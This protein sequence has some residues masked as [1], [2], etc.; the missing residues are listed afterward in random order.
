MPTTRVAWLNP[1]GSGG[2]LDESRR[3]LHLPGGL[4]GDVVSWT[5]VEGHAQVDAVV[6]PSPDRVTPACPVDGQCGGCDL[7]A[8]APGA[9]RAA[10]AHMIGRAWNL[11]AAPEVEAPTVERGR[12]A[13]VELAIA[14][15]VVGYRAAR[16]HRLVDVDACGI[17]RPE[18]ND[19][20]G[21][22]RTVIAARPG[23]PTD[24]V[25]LRTDGEKAVAAFQSTRRW[26]PEDVE[27]T[28]VLD[29]VAVDHKRV[30]GDP[31]LR[32]PVLGLRLRAGPEAFFQVDLD[33]N[34][35]LVAFVRDAITAVRAERV[36]DLYAGIGNLGLPIAAGGVPVLAVE[37]DGS[38]LHDLRATAADHGLTAVKVLAMDARKFDPSRE[39]FDA[40][41][42]D[43]PRAG[44]GD[45]LIRVL[46]NRPRR[47]VLVSCD[48]L[49]GSRDV[50]AAQKLGYRVTAVRCFDLFA[51]SHHME[52]VTVLDR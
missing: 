23:L 36:L 47:V 25:S 50:R 42:L 16:S 51:D 26:S 12:R 35:R 19:L 6:E 18:L 15:G 14:D 1:D 11:P 22:L 34:Q 2:A 38:A 3:V 48:A 10:L 30:H 8:L 33:L 7:S 46:R 20:L 5:S 21:R 52:T 9:R 13:R 24:R 31:T 44:A 41:I 39:A 45:V 17:A 43:P 28:A 4:P 27:G 37:V 40:A 29:H 49:A 32:L